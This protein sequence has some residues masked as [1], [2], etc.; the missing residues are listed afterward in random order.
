MAN[1][2]DSWEDVL[3]SLLGEDAA[4]QAIESM[5]AAS[6]DPSALGEAAGLPSDRQ[7]LMR[8]INQVQALLD[9]SGEGPVNW[10]L[11]HDVAR[12]QVHA[13]GDPS[14]TAAEEARTRQYLQI[15][16][17]W[18]D[19]ITTL[20]PS[21]G[22]RL[23]LSRAGWVERTLGTFQQLAEPVAASVV[24]AIVSTL[25]S[26]SGQVEGLGLAG[27]QAIG[28]MRRLGGAAFGMQLGSAVATLASEAFGFSDIGIPLTGEGA[29]CL[30]PRN[31]DAFSD[32]LDIPVAE[33][34]Q[35]LAVREVA[36]A[37]LYAGAPW[38]RGHVLGI[39]DAYARE[40]RI[41]TAAMEEAFRS[42][43]P[44]DPDQLREAMSS[45]VF[46]LDVT[47]AQRLALARLETVLAVIEGW[48]EEVTGEA[49]RGQLE[50]VVPLTELLRRRRAAGGPAEETFKSLVGLELRPRRLRDAAV[51][52]ANVTR[53]RGAE[54]RDRLWSHPDLMPSTAELDDPAGFA[55]SRAATADFDDALEALL[56]G[57][58]DRD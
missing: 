49:T 7:Q 18:L 47:D 43:D 52:W 26:E 10:K 27:P 34:S 6:I 28:L 50:H 15:A 11:A 9:S 16:D 32:G 2:F 22:E 58:D 54:E 8:M 12:Q 30:V 46:A 53:A 55:A 19:P 14:L 4:R 13:A 5:R 21:G 56:R 48:V 40:I 51:L 37:R 38:L 1:E 25:M 45:G 57:E 41:D 31:V 42:I 39:V 33:V 35:Y 29:V 3:R 23:A 17:L 36:H 24:Q 20:N 44:A